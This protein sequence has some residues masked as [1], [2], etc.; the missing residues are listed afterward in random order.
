M[1]KFALLFLAL[2]TLALPAAFASSSDWDHDDRDDKCR[3]DLMRVDCRFH[4]VENHPGV[5]YCNASAV[6]CAKDKTISDVEFGVSCDDQTLYSDRGT[7]APVDLTKDRITPKTAAWPALEI[8]PQYALLKS[9]VYDDGATLDTHFG[10][11]RGVC[12][13]R[14]LKKW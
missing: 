4:N 5:D 13:V 11:M 14:D 9:G 7:Y 6:Y 10:R 1:K 2:S 8:S 3:G 12:Y